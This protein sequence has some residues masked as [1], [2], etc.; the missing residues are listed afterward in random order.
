MV[1][2]PS[3]PFI[4][5]LY[6]R[7]HSLLLSHCTLPC[8][9]Y[10][11]IFNQVAW[12]KWVGLTLRIVTGNWGQSASRAPFT[13]QKG[14]SLSHL[15]VLTHFYP[16]TMTKVSLFD[17]VHVTATASSFRD[18]ISRYH[19]FRR[20]KR[21]PREGLNRAIRL[22][23]IRAQFHAAWSVLDSMVSD[24]IVPVKDLLC[25]WT[26]ENINHFPRSGRSHW[27]TTNRFLSS[28]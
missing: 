11:S 20:Q 22:A 7:R 19:S 17:N 14:H 15:P 10:P 5:P 6:L 2:H 8:S 3:L 23:S 21:N 16:C 18:L 28:S 25:Y 1:P 27:D 12:L 26:N 9:I 13:A 4:R 24:G